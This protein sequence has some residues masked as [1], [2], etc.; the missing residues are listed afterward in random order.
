MAK[1]GRKQIFHPETLEVG[2]RI[3]LSGSRKIYAHQTAYG[4]N[5]RLKP[6]RFRAII[7]DPKVYIERIK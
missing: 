4:F 1:L 5:R 2:E 6:K 7:K 3:Y